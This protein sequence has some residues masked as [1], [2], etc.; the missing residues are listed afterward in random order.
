[1]LPQSYHYQNLSEGADRVGGKLRGDKECPFSG[2]TKSGRV[3]R[4]VPESD[5][6]SVALALTNAQNTG[7]ALLQ[8]NRPLGTAVS[9]VFYGPPLC[10]PHIHNI[11][12]IMFGTEERKFLAHISLYVHFVDRIKIKLMIMSVSMPYSYAVDGPPVLGP[13]VWRGRRGGEETEGK[14]GKMHCRCWG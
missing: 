14:A 13:Y 11:L 1:M 10:G 7:P 12:F 6:R 2:V 4:K 9:S 8:L 5:A 3:W